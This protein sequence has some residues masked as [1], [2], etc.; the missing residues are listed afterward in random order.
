MPSTSPVHS[1]EQIQAATR[2]VI[3]SRTW[4]AWRRRRRVSS[5]CGPSAALTFALLLLTLAAFATL[6]YGGAG[7]ELL[8]RSGSDIG[9]ARAL[10]ALHQ[11]TWGGVFLLAAMAPLAAL[12][13][14]FVVAF[15]LHLSVA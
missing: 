4:S 1:G 10:Q 5:L 11:V 12:I 13:V 9:D 3:R 2:N 15:V 6:V 7:F 8:V 14:L